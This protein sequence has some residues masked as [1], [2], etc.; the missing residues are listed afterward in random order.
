MLACFFSTVAGWSAG[1]KKSPPLP[2]HGIEGMGG[3][4]STYTAYLVNPAQDGKI[5]GLPSVGFAYVSLGQE[6]HLEALTITETL[7]DRLEIGYALD[8]FDLGDL[9]QD[10]E[11]MTGINID[12]HSV[13]M[14][15]LNFR[16]QAVQESSFDLTWLPAITVGVHYKDNEDIGDIDND[17]SGTLTGIGIDDDDG[18]DFTVYFTKMIT[19]LPRPLLVNAGLRSTKAAH[20]GLLGFTDDRKTLFEGNLVLFVTNRLGLA[21]EY[22]RKPDE[23]NEIPG[24]IKK[25]DDWG[26]LCFCYVGNDHMTFS[27]GYGHLGDVLNHEANSSWGLKAKWEF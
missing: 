1:P 22:R 12:D 17:L 3:V 10:I 4:F 24:L 19:A 5:F 21:I 27:G 14:H 13:N 25:E 23:Y 20:L 8:R 18:W 26:T 6:R 15:N 16:F 9:P 11:R 7:W 2:L